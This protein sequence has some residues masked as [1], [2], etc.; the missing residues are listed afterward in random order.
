MKSHRYYDLE[1]SERHV[2]LDKN[3]IEFGIISGFL[4]SENVIEYEQNGDDSVSKMKWMI[5]A[6]T[7]SIENF[8]QD[9]K[10]MFEEVDFVVADFE[11]PEFALGVL[12]FMPSSDGNS[13]PKDHFDRI[14]KLI[15]FLRVQIRS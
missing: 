2:S 10:K 13:S 1:F 14:E 9:Y 6:L 7:W 15:S 8:K 5:V 3:D 12:S 11:Y 4:K